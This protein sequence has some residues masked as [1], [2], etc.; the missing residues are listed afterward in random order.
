M[1]RLISWWVHNGIA[2]NLLMVAIFLM[3]IFGFF[4]LE[5]EFIPAPKITTISVSGSWLGAS[6]NDIQEQIIS[7]VEQSIEGIDGINYV[8]A[9]ARE[10]FGSVTVH[11]LVTA[12]F[13]KVLDEV[14]A[15]VDGIN[16]LPPD[17]FR[18]QT[19]RGDFQMDYMYLALYAE[20]NDVDRKELQRLGVDLQKEMAK[21]YGGE[22][23]RLITRLDEEITIEIS[24]TDLRRFNLT[25]SQVSQ[26]ISGSSLNS[27]AGEVKT[28]AGA[29]QLRTRSLADSKDEFE[30]IIVRQSTDGGTVRVKD[31]ARVI[32]GFEDVDFFS[33]YKGRS[34][35]FFQV[36][37]P[38]KSNITKTGKIFEKFVEKRAETLPRGIVLEMW[39]NGADGFDGM[40]GLIF[41]N[42]LMGM[43]LVLVFLCF[44]LR[45]AV[46]FWVS[47]GILTAFTG[48]LAI[49]PAMG[50]T[51][52]IFS[53]FAFLLVIGI[54]VDDAIV[55]GESIHLH[56]E[57]GISGERGAIAGANMVA[58]PVFFAVLTTM[59]AFSPWALLSVSVVTIT[60]Q[61]TFV[62][63][64]ALTFSL[65]EA[66]FILPAHLRHLKPIN[67][68]APG[69]LTRIQTAISNSLVTFS[70]KRFR[71][72]AAFC[73]KYRYA[74]FASFMALF[75][76]AISAVQHGYA[77]FSPDGDVSGDMMMVNISFPE[78]TPFT[79][80]LQAQEQLAEAADKLN[81][82]AK[83]DFG[84]DYTIIP[85]PGSFVQGRRLQA[86]MGLAPLEDRTT[87]TNKMIEAKFE[88]YL[89]EFPDAY[90]VSINAGGGGSNNRGLFFGVGAKTPESLM[91]AIADLK[92]QFES[93]SNVRRTWDNFE[94]SAQEM[95]F[96]LKPGAQSLG[97]T[98]AMV[99]QQVREAF[100]GRQVQ[101]LPRDG[102]DV[103]VVVRYPK[104]ARQSIDTLQNLRIRAANGVEVPLYEVA[105][106]TFAPGVTRVNRRDRK[107]V[108]YT[109]ATVKGG[110]EARQD[111]MK[112]LEGNFLPEW[113]L[114][115]PNAERIVI[116]QDEETK[117]QFREL[118]NY[119]LIVLVVMYMMLAIAFSSYSQPFLIL[120][121]IPFAFVGMVA[122]A[123]ITGIPISIMSIFG[124]FAAAGVAINDNL[125]LIDYV[126]RLRSRGV[127]AYQSMVDACVARFRPILLTS[128]TTFVGILPM[129][130]E[131]SSQAEFLKPL[132]VALAFG[133]LFDFFLTLFLVPAMYAMGVDVGRLFKGLWT[134]EKQPKLGSRY[135]P[136]VA[137]ALDDL[138]LED[139]TPARTA[140]QTS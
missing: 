64:A 47:L 90:R 88:E 75:L 52:N 28:S 102:E 17:A 68:N 65:I 130:A 97:I 27:S 22:L 89:G 71:P 94:S 5:R 76:L 39:A 57:N 114:R 38:E 131:R 77:R 111:I 128:L 137:L 61:I 40:M 4:K 140:L 83:E 8:E 20:N 31:I 110:A 51:F 44:F 124:F 85:T 12:D 35:M 7:R 125:V 55:V 100:F 78:G 6:P 41:S 112:D 73:I 129:L 54:I 127:G 138:D 24:E 19:R 18:L 99:S 74:T 84:V 95:Q 109:G 108:A 119:G 50:I 26:A 126:N 21:L 87:I 93:Y 123:L 72:I 92:T 2:A 36:L 3:G 118:T 9:N 91:A 69:R 46:A 62:V 80:L 113:E 101:R 139:A 121:A 34:A 98:L 53:V 66:F 29:L 58:K 132:V 56:V 37:T 70:E 96:T 63:V 86:F 67:Q 59:L 23:T 11:V 107:Q 116:G 134:G 136:D 120:I 14:K 1:K 10:S 48:A 15:R 81:E 135:N 16:N 79:R 25:F 33:E 106:I 117:R 115:H 42:A 133:V 105:E 43:A 82:N 45:P 32:D 30:N 104:S 13:N 103:R 122:G 60:S 49:A